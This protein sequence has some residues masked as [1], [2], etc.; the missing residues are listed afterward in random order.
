MKNLYVRVCSPVSGSVEYRHKDKKC[1]AAA[2]SLLLANL[3][4]LLVVRL[5][6][7]YSAQLP[8]H[9]KGGEVVVVDKNNKILVN[10]IFHKLAVNIKRHHLRLFCFVW[11]PSPELWLLQFRWSTGK[12]KHLCQD[13][14]DPIHSILHDGACSVRLTWLRS[15]LIECWRVR[16]WLKSGLCSV[17]RRFPRVSLWVHSSR[18][19]SLACRR[20]RAASTCWRSV[21]DTEDRNSLWSV[22]SDK[23]KSLECFSWV[24]VRTYL[25]GHFQTSLLCSRRPLFWRT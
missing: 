4:F 6:L 7:S 21:V 24:I 20:S 5:F 16:M 11:T 17:S 23:R 1:V 13:Q 2:S 18:C 3:F 19:T 8:Y 10:E 14:S 22:V 9:E 25:S 12:L 15:C